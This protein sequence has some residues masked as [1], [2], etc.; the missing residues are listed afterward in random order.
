MY[1]L[2]L[3]A[4][5]NLSWAKNIGDFFGTGSGEGDAAVLPTSDG[6]YLVTSSSDSAG[7]PDIS[8]IS[9]IK[10]D[11][12]GNS[13]W[14]KHYNA[15]IDSTRQSPGGI[16]ATADGN[17]AMCGLTQTVGDDPDI[18]LF[19]LDPNGD[20]LWTRTY[21]I[22]TDE[23]S[24]K[25]KQ[26]PDGGYIISGTIAIM[27]TMD[28]PYLLKVDAMGNPQWSRSYSKNGAQIGGYFH[29]IATGGN[30]YVLGG[31]C[32][33]YGS[34]LWNYLLIRTDSTGDTL[35][36]ARYGQTPNFPSVAWDGRRTSDGGYALAGSTA[37][38]GNPAAVNAYLLK[39]DSAGNSGCNQLPYTLDITVLPIVA[40]NIPYF[41]YSTNVSA[42][43][44][45]VVT[46]YAP[47]D[48]VICCH[49]PLVLTG[50][51]TVCTGDS[52]T[53]TASGAYSYLWSNGSTAPSI[54]VGVPADT[55]YTVSGFIGPSFSCE[56]L[57]MNIAAVDVT[58]SVTGT[59][60]ICSGGSTT[61]TASGGTAYLWS[62]GAT[63][64]SINITP[65]STTTYT[66]AV[67]IGSCTVNDSITV[68]VNPTPTAS[69]SGN[70]T[71]CPGDS[72]V[73]TASGGGTYQ[74]NTGETSSVLVTTPGGATTYTVI[75]NL[76]SC[77]DTTTFNVFVNPTP[78][79]SIA[80]ANSICAGDSSTLTA[81]GTGA[82]QWSTG[83]TTPAVTVSP[84]ATASYTVTLTAPTGC[85]NTASF[86]V[87]VT[88]VPVATISGDTSICSGGSTTLTASGGSLFQWSTGATSASVNFSPSTST[89]YSV[90]VSNGACSDT[91]YTG[92]NVLPL[93]VVSTSPDDTVF[94]GNSTVISAS[95]GVSYQWSPSTGLS[96]TN[97]PNPTA[98][99]VATTQYCATVTDADGCSGTACVTVFVDSECGQ[100]F[101]PNAF[102]P[103]NDG[104]N[105]QLCIYGIECIS[106]VQFAVYD[107]W[108]EK[109]FETTDPGICWDGTFR[110]EL[111][112]TAVFVYHLQAV[113]LN[114]EVT[115]K[116][117]NITLV[118]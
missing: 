96:C 52:V 43:H 75:V 54:T 77:A 78:P 71:I 63:T 93:P 31:Y 85:T 3:D 103:N 61:L 20:T 70:D 45:S 84:G 92:I 89:F 107:R 73:L 66:V 108:G 8:M 100:L 97:C 57:T 87:T 15:Q 79:V 105:D 50:M 82:F 86:T 46:N 83:A 110:G 9:L 67:S 29:D 56:S 81:S 104:Q 26:S 21:D 95:G 32:G 51:D 33:D 91:A 65:A 16:I 10:L 34:Q 38:T 58:P 24:A 102:S 48:T 106:E 69:I 72:A 111:M 1:V 117:G 42:N 55:S 114:G 68:T 62:N 30:G 109:V 7:L 116:K 60:V 88:P 80:G 14:Q 2:K 44:P 36:A 53:L 17:Y 13:V 12:G 35:W 6:G 64:S 90:I 11:A 112:N 98:T 5:G 74:W 37:V 59:N 18:F 49:V 41:Q 23:L 118:R 94:I 19:K 47:G 27:S 99:P 39:T 25:I 115:V 113:T 101:V 40:Y 28:Y 76:G 4:S 22:H